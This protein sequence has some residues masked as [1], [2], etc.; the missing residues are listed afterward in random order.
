MH[1][2][3]ILIVDDEEDAVEFVASVVE[4]MGD[5][6]ILKATD[7]E[8]AVETAR[9]ELP[10]LIITD[11]NMPV[12]DGYTAF[13]ELQQ[14][15]VTKGIPVIMLSSLAALGE[16]VTMNP[17]VAQPKLFLDKPID[18][19]SLAAMIRRVLKSA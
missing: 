9:R 17:A 15:K 18:P 3:K 10:A 12:K 16:Y 2:K 14:D 4:S 7:G 8:Q 1:R 13:V 6:E 11:V 5:Y 19:D